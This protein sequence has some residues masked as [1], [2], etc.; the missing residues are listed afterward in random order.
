VGEFFKNQDTGSLA[1]DESIPV[2]VPGA[3]GQNARR[4]PGAYSGEPFQGLQCCQKAS[5]TA[6]LLGGLLGGDDVLD[7]D[8]IRLAG[9]LRRGNLSTR[10]AGATLATLG[11]G[12]TWLGV[13]QMGSSSD[14]ATAMKAMRTAL[15]MQ[16]DA[17]ELIRYATLAPNG[18]N[19]QPWRFSTAPG[20]ITIQP[21]FTR[22]TPVV[23]PDDHH[24]FVS[25]GCAAENLALASAARGQLPHFWP[26]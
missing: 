21:D 17:G 3:G 23:D 16:P 19:A 9:G 25:L 6:E 11:A 1:Q 26:V 12:A 15:P 22:R 2:A 24:L 20:L 8:D 18:H 14:Y 13:A 5:S 10:L 4:P 7:R